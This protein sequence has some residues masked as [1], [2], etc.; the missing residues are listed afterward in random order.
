MP[1]YSLGESVGFPRPEFADEDGLLAIGGDLRAERLLNAYASGIF[2][3]YS[4]GEPLL[5]W[6]PDPRWVLPPAEVHVSSSMKSVLRSGKF[7]VTFDRAFRQVME[8]C[9]STPRQGQ[10]GTWITRDMVEAYCE[11]HQYH[12]AHSVEVWHEGKLVGGLYGISL[13]RMFFGESMFSRMSNA[14][15]M[16]FIW[17]AKGLERLQFHLIDCQT[18][19][20]HLE[21]L[22]ARAMPRAHF[23]RRLEQSLEHETLQLP[24]SQLDEL[25]ASPLEA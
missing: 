24:W 2:P 20:P 12:L 5:W 21:S 6:S 19:T 17:L 14:S 9:G 13:G 10:S 8:A 11:M 25:K 18:H 15:K 1:V 7:K 22:G 3:W 16:G 4:E 23:L